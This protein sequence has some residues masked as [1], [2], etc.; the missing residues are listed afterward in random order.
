MSD[1]DKPTNPKLHKLYETAKRLE[2]A[3]L[4]RDQARQEAQIRTSLSDA[5][6]AYLR[7]Q[8]ATL[9]DKPDTADGQ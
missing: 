6:K 9:P 4:R 3:R 1:S 2:I 7:D 5:M 8:E